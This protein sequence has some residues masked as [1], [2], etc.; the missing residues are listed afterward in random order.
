MAM[1]SDYEIMMKLL[2]KDEA[3]AAAVIKNSDDGFDCPS[4]LLR[5]TEMLNYLFYFLFELL[6]G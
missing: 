1:D 4:T 3:G 6:Y 2:M 5:T